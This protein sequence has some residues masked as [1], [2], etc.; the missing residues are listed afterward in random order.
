MKK[1]KRINVF[2][3]NSSSSHSFSISKG[4]NILS[5]F[6]VKVLRSGVLELEPKQYGWEWARF[7]TPEEKLRYILTS[8]PI[9]KEKEIIK[10][11][12][13]YAGIKI[14]FNKQKDYHDYIDHQSHFMLNEEVKDKDFLLNLVFN[15][16]AYIETGNDNSSNPEKI[17]TEHGKVWYFDNVVENIYKD[18]D[19]D[20]NIE[21][22]EFDSFNE[23]LKTSSE[24]EIFLKEDNRNK[25]NNDL[26]DFVVISVDMYR[27]FQYM[28]K[29]AIKSLCDKELYELGFK[30]VENYKINKIEKYQAEEDGL[31]KVKVVNTLVPKKNR[32]LKI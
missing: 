25:I 31:L 10:T 24:V 29:S 19:N 3:T 22:F 18:K 12:E 16:K 30:V 8:V 26:K 20:D 23:V 5:N 7:Y 28:D 9:G 1:V 27:D 6:D 21:V 2:E 17:L 4:E 14:K 32:K 13:E 15:E 11:I